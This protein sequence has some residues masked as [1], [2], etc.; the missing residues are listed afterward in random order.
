MS[1]STSV[2]SSSCG[3]YFFM[4]SKVAALTYAAAWQWE[5]KKIVTPI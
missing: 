5:K 4:S 3:S 2:A 1:E